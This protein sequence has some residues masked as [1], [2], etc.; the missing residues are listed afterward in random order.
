[1]E[2]S[3]LRRR[4]CL[5]EQEEGERKYEHPG[6]EAA[7]SKQLG[8]NLVERT[9]RSAA[10]QETSDVTGRKNKE[11]HERTAG[12]VRGQRHKHVDEAELHN[13]PEAP[14]QTWGGSP[15]AGKDL[16][17]SLQ[18]SAAKRRDSSGEGDSGMSEGSFSD[19]KQNLAT[20]LVPREDDS[21]LYG[22]SE[23]ML[24]LLPQTGDSHSDRGRSCRCRQVTHTATEVGRSCCHRQGTHTATEVGPAAADR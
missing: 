1:V 3:S 14:P 18:F 13:V 8:G 4:Q 19:G 21:L 12:S 24:V 23:L 11:N 9:E 22:S 17:A 2:D 20:S 5:E 16:K 7:N 15:E 10:Q 6:K